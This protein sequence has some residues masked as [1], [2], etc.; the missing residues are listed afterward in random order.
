[1][2]LIKMFYLSQTQ[3]KNLQQSKIRYDSQHCDTVH[4]YKESVLY[5]FIHLEYSSIAVNRCKL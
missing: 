1:M 4:V 5:A 3:E 2:L